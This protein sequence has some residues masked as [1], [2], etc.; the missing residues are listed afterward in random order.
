MSAYL[1]GRIQVID[2]EQYKEYM[3]ASTGVTEKFGGR[4]I[5]RGGGRVTLEGPEETRRIVLIEFPS[6]DQV[7]VFYRSREYAE[8]KKLREGAAIA[9]FI[10]VEG[11]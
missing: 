6:L 9:S 8:I 1:I 10:A 11:V 4:F 5:V 2:L 7:K 3:K